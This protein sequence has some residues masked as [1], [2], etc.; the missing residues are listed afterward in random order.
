MAGAGRL[1]RGR[2]ALRFAASGSLVLWLE[3]DDAPAGL[4]AG[5]SGRR[6]R[7]PCLLPGA[8]VEAVGSRRAA[9][10][11][12]GDESALTRVE[13]GKA[14]VEEGRSY[15]FRD[16]LVRAYPGRWHSVSLLED[17][18][19]L[20]L[21]EDLPISQDEAYIERAYK[22]LAGVQLKKARREGQIEPWTHR[23]K[24]TAR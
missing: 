12:V 17:G 19:A 4:A 23:R 13:L 18:K 11:P 7:R 2:N 3:G 16:A 9:D 8:G 5:Y 10:V 24:R 20:L 14:S 22:I 21:A 6:R 15:E 1:L